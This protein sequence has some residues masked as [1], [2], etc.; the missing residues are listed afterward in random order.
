MSKCIFILE[1]DTHS[2]Y[3]ESV[4]TL[5]LLTE[6]SFDVSKP[7]KIF[8]LCLNLFVLVFHADSCIAIIKN[9]TVNYYIAAEVLRGMWKSEK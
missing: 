3:Q 2:N 9:W 8:S 6:D 1:P 4:A 5:S 7:K